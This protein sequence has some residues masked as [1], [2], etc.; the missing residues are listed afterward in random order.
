MV[1]KGPSRLSSEIWTS[2]ARRSYRA[3]HLWL[4]NQKSNNWDGLRLIRFR[5][6]AAAEGLSQNGDSRQ[7]RLSY[8]KIDSGEDLGRTF[9]ERL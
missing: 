2:C 4:T 7:D 8:L 3:R 6:R 9:I 1:S 5:G